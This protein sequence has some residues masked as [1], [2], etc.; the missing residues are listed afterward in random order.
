MIGQMTALFLE[1][2]VRYHPKCMMVH[3]QIC[4]PEHLLE[5]LQFLLDIPNLKLQFYFVH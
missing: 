4:C 2:D 5:R 1:R 3:G